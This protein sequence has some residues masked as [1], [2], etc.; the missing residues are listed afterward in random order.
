MSGGIDSCSVVVAYA[1]DEVLGEPPDA[2]HLVAWMGSAIAAGRDWALRSG[3]VGQLAR[4]AAV[5]VT[6]PTASATLAWVA[7]RAVRRSPVVA[8]LVT[9]ALLKPTFA[10]GALRD[11]A[12]VVRDALDR[13]DLDAARRALGSLC[14]RDATGLDAASLTAATIE[15]VAENTS[16][17]VVA[18]LFFFACFGLSGAVFY[19]AANTLDAMIGYHGRFE[20]AGKAAARLDDLL[21]F[22]PARITAALL[23]S[24]VGRGRPPAPPRF[25]L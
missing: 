23:L 2:L 4:G 24:F 16:D 13:D 6:I 22:V 25:E 8:V 20:Y 11:A 1:L 3:R 17:S 19:R 18:P 12:F 15:S 9:A 21:N 14:S 7:T 5:A 10:V